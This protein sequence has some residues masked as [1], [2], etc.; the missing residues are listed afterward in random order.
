MPARRSVALCLLVLLVAIP[1]G[2][3][4]CSK[5]ETAVERG[6]REQ[7]LLRGMGPEPADLDPHLATT[8]N[9]YTVLS[10][11]FEGLVAED[12]Q[13]LAPV[14][15]VAERWELSPDGLTYTFHLRADAHWS[16][17]EPVTARDFLA[18]WQRVLTPSLAADNASLLYIVQNAEAFHKGALTDFTKVG[19][20]APDARTVRISLEHPASYFL[21]LLQ[22]W[23]W[24]PVHLPTLHKSGDPYVRGNPWARPDTFVGN[25][26]FTLK[27]WRTGQHIEVVKSLTYWDRSI[28]QLK[29]IRFLPIEDLNAEERAFRSGQLH[30]TEALP[31]AKVAAYRADHPELLRIDPYLGTYYYTLNTNRPFLNEV[32][33]RRALALAVD[34]A[35][36]AEKILCGGQTPA[37]A[38]TPPGTAGY[39]AAARFSTDYDEARRLL[40]EA[41]Y[42]GGKGAPILELLLNTSDNHRII[43][44]AV[45]AGWRRELGLEV[46]L[47]NM[48][49]KS[50][51]A[52]RRA[53][54][55]QILRS[56]WIGDYSDPATFLSVWTSD[57]GNN[58]SGW[59]K[60]AYDQLLF[61]AA[62]TADTE[63]RH[64]L[65]QQAEA[66]LVA[67]APFIPLYTY[68][69]VFLKN[70]AVKGWHS[71]LL[72]HHPYKH[73]SL[74]AAPSS[75]T[76]PQGNN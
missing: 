7:T 35:G 18:S 39:T 33:I 51:L 24:W 67:D 73:V 29:A 68:T 41:G 66:L 4:G 1:F 36:I 12:P 59:R 70:P 65:F 21:S 61:Q 26:P 38:F 44:E 52:A 6:N 15:G 42:P 62:R 14:P 69:H 31:L 9:D 8:A 34:R 22:H 64:D 71:T 55:F 48:E 28:V 27:E 40:T 43:A 25:G 32:K 37:Y 23:V 13:T 54:D 57:S 11:L 72:D 49:G 74:E 50:V 30:L 45:Q 46:R 19:F 76:A 20:S 16:N 53:G 17:G 5:R 56:S 10:A 60:P 75:S 2:L 47:L 3:T 58:S 63:A